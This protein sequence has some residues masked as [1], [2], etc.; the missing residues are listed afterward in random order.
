[1]LNG[2]QR[3]FH[4]GVAYAQETEGHERRNPPCFER[5]QRVTTAW[6]RLMVS[7]QCKIWRRVSWPCIH[8]HRIEDLKLINLCVQEH[9]V[10]AK[11]RPIKVQEAT[12]EQ[13][14]YV[15]RVHPSGASKSIPLIQHCLLF[16]G[17]PAL[18][19]PR[20]TW[21]GSIPSARMGALPS[22]RTFLQTR[23]RPGQPSCRPV[24]C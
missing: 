13:L 23:T 1:M 12:P 24:D 9:A 11:C 3:E 7:R 6:E 2:V 22:P 14:R 8:A 19:I 15:G 21:R 20:P 4:T 18:C 5:P 17:I 16:V 10:L